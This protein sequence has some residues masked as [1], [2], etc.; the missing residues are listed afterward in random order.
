MRRPVHYAFIK[1]R[2]RVKKELMSSY[3]IASFSLRMIELMRFTMFDTVFYQIEL[4]FAVQ[5]LCINPEQHFNIC[6]L[7]GV[8]F[9]CSNPYEDD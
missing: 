5:N 4:F 9:S 3:A 8:F 6:E 2:R 1:I 7:M